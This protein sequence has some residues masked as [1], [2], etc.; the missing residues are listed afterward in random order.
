M[1]HACPMQYV[2]I[3]DDTYYFQAIHVEVS[4]DCLELTTIFDANLHLTG[5]Q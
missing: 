3:G 5:N 2:C 4:K 1:E